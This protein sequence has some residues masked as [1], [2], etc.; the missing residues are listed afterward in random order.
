MAASLAEKKI[1]LEEDI[2]EGEVKG[3]RDLLMS[4]FINLMDNSRKALKAGGIISLWG[5]E[6]GRRVTKSASGIMA[7]V[8]LRRSSA[9]LQRL[10]YGRQSRS[11]NRGSRLG[12]TLCSRIVYLHGARWRFRVIR[13]R[14]IYLYLL[15]RKGGTQCIEGDGNMS[16]AFCWSVCW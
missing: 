11:R 14:D 16:S 8:F 2:E 1:H 6:P 5:R 4:L 9:G 12:L 13:A 10:L 3:D 7:A 15:S